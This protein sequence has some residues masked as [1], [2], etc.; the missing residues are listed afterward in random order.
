MRKSAMWD[1]LW[2]FSC[3]GLEKYYHRTNL[4]LSLRPI[5]HF[6]FWIE[7]F[8][9]LAQKSRNCSLKPLLRTVA[10]N[11]KFTL[12]FHFYDRRTI[13]SQ[14]KKKKTIT[15]RYGYEGN[16]RFCV[17]WE[18]KLQAMCTKDSSQV[19]GWLSSVVCGPAVPTQQLV[20]RVSHFFHTWRSVST[21]LSPSAWSSSDNLVQKAANILLPLSVSVAEILDGGISHSSRTLSTNSRMFLPVCGE[22]MQHTARVTVCRRWSFW[23]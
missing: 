13:H 5:V 20:G 9:A 10:V 15:E 4:P 17:R 1:F 21:L 16:N 14:A 18:T 12:C 7:R 22:G 3:Y 23:E 8:C 6:G 11:K 19:D 2:S